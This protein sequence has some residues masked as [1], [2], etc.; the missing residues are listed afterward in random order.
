M[1]DAVIFGFD[2]RPLPPETRRL[3]YALRARGGAMRIV[4]GDDYLRR[5]GAQL[6]CRGFAV[7]HGRRR[8]ALTPR[9]DLYLD[10]LM[11]AE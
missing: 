3:M 2:F 4:R 6:R 1:A 10:K 5:L 11:R 7:F 9:G 8:L